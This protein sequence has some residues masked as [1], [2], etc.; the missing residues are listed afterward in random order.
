MINGQKHLALKKNFIIEFTHVPSGKFVLFD[1]FIENYSDDFATG[2]SEQNVYGRQDPIMTFKNTT[3]TMTLGFGVIANSLSE[4]ISNLAKI[5]VLMAM[6]YPHYSDDENSTIEAAPLMKIRFAN[7]AVDI[8]YTD[9]EENDREILDN[10]FSQQTVKQGEDSEEEVIKPVLNRIVGA[11]GM[12]AACRG[13]SYKPDLTQGVFMGDGVVFPKYVPIQC[14][15]TVL[16]TKPLGW[17]TSQKRNEISVALGTPGGN[18]EW[19]GPARWPYGIGGL[20]QRYPGVPNLAN[21]K[22]IGGVK[23]ARFAALTGQVAGTTRAGDGERG[24]SVDYGDYDF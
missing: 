6:L 21:S 7:M 15:F 17:K 11:Q 18:S 22:I 13:F 23:A 8:D 9:E 10:F 4:S 14:T 19:R 20:G 24:E 5:E 16:H 12:L 3:R 2:W 1:G